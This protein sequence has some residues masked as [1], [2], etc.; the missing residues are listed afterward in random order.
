MMEYFL[1]KRFTASRKRIPPLSRRALDFLL[2]CEWPVRM[3]ELEN[4]A[5]EMVAFGD[6]PCGIARPAIGKIC[7]S[8]PAGKRHSPPTNAASRIVPRQAER[9]PTSGHC[10][11]FGATQASL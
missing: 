4:L 8:N 6:G 3:R 2:S 7:E 10:N 1:T 9:R 11:E 5:L